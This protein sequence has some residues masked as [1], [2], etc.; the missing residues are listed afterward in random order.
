MRLLRRATVQLAVLFRWGILCEYTGSDH[1]FYCVYIYH[2][3]VRSQFTDLHISKFFG[4][5]SAEDGCAAANEQSE[6]FYF[7]LDKDYYEHGFGTRCKEVTMWLDSRN[8]RVSATCQGEEQ[9]LQVKTFE[10]ELIDSGHV[11][12][13]KQVFHRCKA[14]GRQLHSVKFSIFNN[15]PNSVA[16]AFFESNYRNQFAPAP[17]EVY[18]LENNGTRTYEIDCATGQSIC[19][20]AAVQGDSSRSFWGVG[21]DGKQLCSGCCTLCPREEAVTKSLN[22]WDS[23]HPN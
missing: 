11:R 22:I 9:G 5:W 20:G 3:C 7:N 8:L 19:Y 13:G 15:T 1:H 4:V 10:I 21:H 16:I 17:G 18:T 23:R 6:G 2:S 12:I 14:T